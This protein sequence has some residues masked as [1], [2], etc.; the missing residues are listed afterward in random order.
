MAKRSRVLV[1][2]V[3]G[4]WTIVG[5]SN[6]FGCLIVTLAYFANPPTQ[7][8]HR[9]VLVQ[10]LSGCLTLIAAGTAIAGIQLMRRKE[11]AR[12]FLLVWAW[13]I[14]LIYLFGSLYTWSLGSQFSVRDIALY[15]LEVALIL[16]VPVL[17]LV[18]LHSRSLKSE[19]VPARNP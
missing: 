12:I 3:G 8:P 6:A 18:A 13:L 17:L 16:L 4:F 1:Y 11:R 14:I 15:V 5:L 10:V 7:V 9:A 19:M 2:L